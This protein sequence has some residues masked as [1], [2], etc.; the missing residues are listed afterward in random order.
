MGG[1][2]YKCSSCEFTVRVSS[3]QELEEYQ[4][5]HSHTCN[6]TL[7]SIWKDYNKMS[8]KEKKKKISEVMFRHGVIKSG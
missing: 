4:Q 2:T 8:M 5:E 6:G 3:W 1:S 7:E